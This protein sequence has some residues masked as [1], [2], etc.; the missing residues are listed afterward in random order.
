MQM[1]YQ[2]TSVMYHLLQHKKRAATAAL[3]TECYLS[4]SDKRP[5]QYN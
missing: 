1:I 4:P 5:D 3:I 2:I